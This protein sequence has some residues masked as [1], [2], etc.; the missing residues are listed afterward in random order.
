VPAALKEQL[1]IGGRLVMPVGLDERSQ[2][3]CELTRTS[4]TDFE[5]EDL[6]SVM[7]V[8]LISE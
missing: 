5:R 1:A 2:T 6:G 7:F 8:P 3:L 4:E